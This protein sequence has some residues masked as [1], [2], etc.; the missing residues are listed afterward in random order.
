MK[1]AEAILSGTI[2]RQM[3]QSRIRSRKQPQAGS[4]NELEEDDPKMKTFLAQRTTLFSRLGSATKSLEMSIDEVQPNLSIYSK[5][6]PHMVRLGRT[7]VYRARWT[8]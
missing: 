1:T 3:T 8:R 6:V 4:G 2:L 5:E 7:R